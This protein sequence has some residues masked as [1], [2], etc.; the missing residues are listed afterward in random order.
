VPLDSEL[1]VSLTKTIAPDEPFEDGRSTVAKRYRT[2][3][4]VTKP[5]MVC[6]MI[7]RAI[8]AGR[9]A[10][11][12]LA[13]AW[14]GTKA[15]IRLWQETSL[16]PILCMKMNTMKYR[17][18]EMVRGQPV[19]QELT[20]KT[21]YK[22]RVRKTWQSF[23]GQK[24]QANTVDVELNLAAAKDP[25]AWVKVRLLFVRGQSGE[26]IAPVGKHDWAVFLTTDTA[27]S[28]TDMLELSLRLE[29]L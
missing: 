21:R 23:A 28:A 24:Y 2:A 19:S 18:T 10:D 3:Q 29:A 15:M 1:F 20:C 27:L 13:D 8:S 26:S 14:F 6:A 5:E 7:K 25:D 11:Y 17:H 22:H 16:I 9:L 4:L 12:F